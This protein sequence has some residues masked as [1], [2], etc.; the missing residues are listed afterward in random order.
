MVK[1]TCSPCKIGYIFLIIWSFVGLAYIVMDVKNALDNQEAAWQAGFQEGVANIVGQAIQL[2]D[3][4]QQVP[5]VMGE[6]QINLIN[7]ECLQAS[8]SAT[9]APASGEV[10][11]VSEE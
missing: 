11:P 4:C 7:V 3:E 8:E 5:L 9:E 1:N 2:S 10:A 6:K